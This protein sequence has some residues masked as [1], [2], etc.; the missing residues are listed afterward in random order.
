MM[1]NA[2]KKT[3]N[4]LFFMKATLLLKGADELWVFLP[5]T[6]NEMLELAYAS[7]PF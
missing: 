1:N 2:K 5:R 3:K 4:S 6:K 7:A